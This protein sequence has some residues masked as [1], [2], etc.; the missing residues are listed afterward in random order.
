MKQPPGNLH[1]PLKSNPG[2]GLPEVLETGSRAW[3]INMGTPQNGVLNQA[4]P[5]EPTRGGFR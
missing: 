3:E 2:R 5:V 4:P 1:F